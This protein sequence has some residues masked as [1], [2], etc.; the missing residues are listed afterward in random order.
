MGEGLMK[1]KERIL[2]AVKYLKE[3][4]L[5]AQASTV[6]AVYYIIASFWQR[7]NLQRLTGFATAIGQKYG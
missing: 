7:S 4:S 2:A 6:A 5:P 1:V 3:V